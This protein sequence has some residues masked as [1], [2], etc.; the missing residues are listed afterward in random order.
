MK[1]I[2]FLILLI[3]ITASCIQAQNHISK[4]ATMSKHFVA[5][6]HSEFLNTDMQLNDFLCIAK[7]LS[8][9]RPLK[10]TDETIL[11]RDSILYYRTD[12]FTHESYLMAK[13]MSY[14]DESS[15]VSEMLYYNIPS[16][17][18][19]MS[20]SGK[21]IPIYE[22][23][24]LMSFSYQQWSNTLNM[25][26]NHYK[27]DYEYDDAGRTTLT[28]TFEGIYNLPDSWKYNDRWEFSYDENGNL[29]EKKYAIFDNG[30]N[31]NWRYIDRYTYAYDVENCMREE[32]NYGIDFYDQT[33]HPSY[34][35]EYEY[36]INK[37]PTLANKFHWVSET[38]QW[39]LIGKDV[40]THDNSGRLITD[41]YVIWDDT[42][43]LWINS[44]KIENT[45]L[46]G[47]FPLERIN[48]TWD[49]NINDWVPI[50]KT[51]IERNELDLVLL[52]L[53]SIWS[54]DTIT[55]R[56]AWRNLIQEEYTY[57]EFRNN[58][59]SNHQTWDTINEVWQLD[60][61]STQHYSQHILIDVHT[62]SEISSIELYPNPVIETLNIKGLTESGLV[63]IYDISGKLVLNT[64]T[65]MNR[66]DISRLPSGIYFLTLQNG[67][68]IRFEKQ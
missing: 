38:S 15:Q 59:S 39:D 32:I 49:S 67:I 5:N 24:L 43:E 26:R 18:D 1:K 14:Y 11:L 8:S 10:S 53:E 60:W 33:W 58:L 37:L 68:A 29:L 48:L 23:E 65:A 57:D 4:Q 51:R 47:N 62:S 22:G 28:T 41:L 56:G 34:K 2:Y 35:S 50:R 9:N 13:T 21:Y 31:Q 44:S 42:Q 3:F 63:Q 64:S 66:I 40:F 55:C 61:F 27:V 7:E 54:T 17:G 20:I 12:D 6:E 19:E 45:Y 25:F 46:T 30:T 16:N 52:S 36:N